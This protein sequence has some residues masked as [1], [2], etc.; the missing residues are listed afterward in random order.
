MDIKDPVA[1]QNI[2]IWTQTPCL[3]GVNCCKDLGA[4]FLLVF[5]VALLVNKPL[6]N[7][8]IRM[9]ILMLDTRNVEQTNDVCM[10]ILF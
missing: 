7:G 1:F 10:Y 4:F 5:I 2:M 3:K 8:S 9:Y 6:L